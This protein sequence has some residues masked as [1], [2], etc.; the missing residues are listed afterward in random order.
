MLASAL[1]C[2]VAGVSDGDTL[3]AR[4]GEPWRYEQVKVRLQGIDALE[5]KQPFGDRARQVPA[6]LT[7]QKKVELR[8]TKT[9]RSK[10]QV[11]SV[12]V[13][14]ASAPTGPRT[15]DAGF[16]MITQGMAWWYRAYAREQSPQERGQYEFAEQEAA[17][18]KAGRWDDSQP[19]A[20][21]DWRKTAREATQGLR[22]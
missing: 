21:W 19:I 2:L 7:F 17:A 22:P 3:T 12:W 1:I 10:R 11:C 15:L 13:A 14:P 5:R 4:C 8:C 16:A 6:E 18:R 20:P 9:D